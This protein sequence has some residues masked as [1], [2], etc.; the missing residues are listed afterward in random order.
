MFDFTRMTHWKKQSHSYQVSGMGVH[1]GI[2]SPEEKDFFKKNSLS[3]T[4]H[5]AI[6]PCQNSWSCKLKMLALFYAIHFQNYF[7]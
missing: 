7:V 1:R 4:D 3:C 5:I 2:N 6:H